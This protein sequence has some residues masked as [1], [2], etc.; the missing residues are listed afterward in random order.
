MEKS[1]AN[2]AM[3]EELPVV[4]KG[5]RYKRINAIIA[6]RFI[7]GDFRTAGVVLNSTYNTVIS[8]ELY[9]EHTNSVTIAPIEE[10]EIVNEEVV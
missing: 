1:I 3:I 9:E 2:K 8:L 7:G 4:H 6:R 5:R 10:V